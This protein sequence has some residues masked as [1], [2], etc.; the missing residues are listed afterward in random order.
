MRDFYDIHE[1][2]SA[3][4][5]IL[6]SQSALIS[7]HNAFNVITITAI[8]P[9][10]DSSKLA[11]VTHSDY[12]F[13]LSLGLPSTLYMCCI[14]TN[15]LSWLY[16]VCCIAEMKLDYP[17]RPCVPLCNVCATYFIVVLAVM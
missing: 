9:V 10:Q 11:L 1:W 14:M 2:K 16:H 6:L 12:R 4:V 17:A 13:V 3:L 7:R 5:R 8:V 15:R